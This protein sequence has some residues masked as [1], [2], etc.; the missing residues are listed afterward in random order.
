MDDDGCT[1]L[2]QRPGGDPRRSTIRR[3]Q[4]KFDGLPMVTTA[5]ADG[6][7]ARSSTRPTTG[8]PSTWRCCSAGSSSRK[9]TTSH[10][11]R[12]TL[13]AR[14]AS[15]VSRPNPPAPMTKSGGVGTVS[16]TELQADGFDNPV[17]VL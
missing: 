7:R 5:L 2:A 4:V 12:M 10:V 1:T 16:A 17:L 6:C 3:R 9:P 15:S 11:G 13:Q 8:T 14:T